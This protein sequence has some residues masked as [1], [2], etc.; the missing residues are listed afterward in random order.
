MAYRGLLQLGG[1][2]IANSRRAATYFDSVAKPRLT[3]TFDDSWVH[4]ARHLG[5][6]EYRL[7]KL[8]TAPWF[9]TAD[10]DSADFGGVWPMA[11]EGLDTAT[12]DREVVPGNGDGATF[13]LGRYNERT[14][15]VDAILYG[16]NTAG[17][18]YGVRW[19]T[20]ILRGDRCRGD[21]SGQILEYLST[22]PNVDPNLDATAFAACIAPYRRQLY[23]VVMTKAP[24]ITERFGVDEDADA[25]TA[26]AYR[27]KFELTAGVPWAYRPAGLLASGLKFVTTGLPTPIYFMICDGTPSTA[28]ANDNAPLV[29]PL[30][31]SVATLV[32]PIPPKTITVCEPL[33]TRRLTTTIPKTA[34]AKFHDLVTTMTITAGSTDA[35]KLRIRWVRKPAGITDVT[36]LLDCYTIRDIYVSYIPALSILTLDGPTNKATVKLTNGATIDASSVVTGADGGPWRPPVLSCADDYMVI[37]D[38]PG[39]VSAGLTVGITGTVRES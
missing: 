11:V 18:D 3:K 30:T 36:T 12:W 29:D 19:L 33:E 20:S 26:T 27:V 39:D 14:I 17:L 35:R 23:D 32:R 37:I 31:P 15:A 22:A 4:T 21:Y 5:Q 38:A 7:P 24:E 34:L 13:G 6:Q 1:V 2:E 10:P 8:D 9:D 25:P 28:C 16:A